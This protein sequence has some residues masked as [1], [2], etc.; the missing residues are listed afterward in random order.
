MRTTIKNLLLTAVL[1]T[2]GLAG[3]AHAQITPLVGGLYAGAAV[4]HTRPEA[5]GIDSGYG[6]HLYGGLDLLS[7]PMIA[8]FGLEAG[9]LRTHRLHGE[10]GHV[11]NFSG[12]AMATLTALPV[13][14]LHA[15]VG[16]EDGDTSGAFQAVGVTLST[17]PMLGIRGE[18][19]RNNGFDALTLGLRVRI[20]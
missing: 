14:D 18:Y 17:F 12:S 11:A 9:Y 13:I 16:Y 6:S 19:S 3:A 5:A 1:G 8:R 7:I 15:R 2:L 4:A 10:I 20:P